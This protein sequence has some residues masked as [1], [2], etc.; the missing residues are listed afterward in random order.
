M[1]KDRLDRSFYSRPTLLVARECLGKYLVFGD[2]IGKIVET[3][4]YLGPEDLASHARFKSRKRNYLMFGQAGVAYVYFTYGMHHMF[5]IVTEQEGVAGAVL[6]RAVQ[7]VS[8]M[9]A[10]TNGP[11][12]LTKA[13]Q[14]TREHNGLDITQGPLYL[15]DWNE[16]ALSRNLGPSGPNESKPCQYVSNPY[17]AKNPEAFQGQ[18]LQTSEPVITTPRIGIDYAGAYKDKPWRFILS[19]QNRN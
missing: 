17:R 18:V 5:N 6:I 19:H 3:E 16:P 10:E 13:F 14:I 8:G 11:G 2:K 12:K 1:A 15:E 7:L 9:A 4:G